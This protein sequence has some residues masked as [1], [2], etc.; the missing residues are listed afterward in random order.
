MA[1]TRYT[2]LVNKDNLNEA[3]AEQFNKLKQ[4]DLKVSRAWA[5]KARF[6]D[7][8]DYRFD[9]FRNSILDQK[10]QLLKLVKTIG[11]IGSIQNKVQERGRQDSRF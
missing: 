2:W 10:I 4:T 6:R 7:F 5:I 8:W 3:F 9:G 1:G 11:D